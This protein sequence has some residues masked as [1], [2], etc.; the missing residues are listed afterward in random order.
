MK[1]PGCKEEMYH[2]ITMRDMNTDIDAAGTK[3]LFRQYEHK[4][5]HEVLSCEVAFVRVYIVD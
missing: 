2:T 4:Q 1:C 5:E 3:A